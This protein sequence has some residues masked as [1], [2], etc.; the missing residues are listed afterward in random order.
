MTPSTLGILVSAG[1]LA[2]GAFGLLLAGEGLDRHLSRRKAR[3]ISKLKR[4]G[5]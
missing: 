1:L 5:R 3:R 4:R 2:A